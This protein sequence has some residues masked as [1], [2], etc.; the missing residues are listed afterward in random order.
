MPI[1]GEPV[2]IVAI[3][4][5]TPDQVRAVAEREGWT[6]LMEPTP[7]GD[8]LRWLPSGLARAVADVTQGSSQPDEPGNLGRLHIELSRPAREEVTVSFSGHDRHGTEKNA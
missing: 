8:A 1:N 2:I 6:L 5:A 7:L 4:G 3:E